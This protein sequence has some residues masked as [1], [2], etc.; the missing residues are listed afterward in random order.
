MVETVTFDFHARPL[1]TAPP[2]TS[3]METPESDIS[4]IQS[5]NMQPLPTY[6]EHDNLFSQPLLSSVDLND[7]RH[8]PPTYT[9]E[10]T[11]LPIVDENSALLPDSRKDLFTSDNNDSASTHP[12]THSSISE[13]NAINEEE[14][15]DEA[16]AKILQEQE[17]NRQKQNIIREY[18]L[19][20]KQEKPDVI[21]LFISRGLVT[22]NTVDE[23]GQT[24]LLAAVATK[25]IKIVQQLLDLGA[26][27]DAFG[28]VVSTSLSN[29]ASENRCEQ[30]TDTML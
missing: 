30:N 7:T 1:G 17:T 11:P 5:G 26:E 20:I 4:A 10:I 25:N 22:A 15:T 28:V 23:D 24:P 14:E 21:D 29:I 16:Y 9:E 6:S 13:T 27:P 8:V 2:P 18:F 3:T 19:G 12:A